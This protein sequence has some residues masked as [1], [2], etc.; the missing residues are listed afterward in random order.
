MS[1]GFL[2]YWSALATLTRRDIC[3]FLPIH[4]CPISES[5][6]EAVRAGPGTQFASLL[7]QPPSAIV[8]SVLPLG[9]SGVGEPEAGSWQSPRRSLWK[10]NAS[11]LA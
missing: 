1:R 8:P 2:G 6:V 4:A 7:C 5:E 11:S 3:L 10:G 9:F